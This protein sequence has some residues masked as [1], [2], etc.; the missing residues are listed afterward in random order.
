MF[1]AVQD[2]LLRLTPSRAFALFFGCF[3]ISTVLIFAEWGKP[4][5]PS[6][7]VIAY[8]AVLFYCQ[9]WLFVQLNATT[10]DS[11]YFLGFLLTL[12]ALLQVL[13]LDLSGAV[14]K[15]FMVR[16]VGAAIL[17]T[18]CGLFMRQL[19]LSRDPT[20]EAQDRVFQGLADEIRKDTLEFH[21]AQKLFVGLV[22]EFVQTREEMFA[23]EEKAFSQYIEGLQEGATILG[24]IQRQYPK[25]VE[26]LLDSIETTVPKSMKSRTSKRTFSR[27]LRNRR[28]RSLNVEENQWPLPATS[29]TNTSANFVLDWSKP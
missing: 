6:L 5:S 11:P 9:K 1:S 2:F 26:N 27:H 7:P 21:Q 23:R 13:S 10:K 29:L 18:I 8:G 3:A 12:I 15:E 14:N 20:E 17:T 25:R 19:L 4:L 16:E 22:K 24:K 28:S